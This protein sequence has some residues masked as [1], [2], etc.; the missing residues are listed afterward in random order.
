MQIQ[1]E[2]D[3]TVFVAN[4]GSSANEEIIFELFLQAGPLKKVTIARDREG[5]QRSYGFVYYKHAEAVPYAIALLNGTW[6]FGR[7][8]RL[9]YGTGSSHQD[10]GSGPQGT[11]DDRDDPSHDTPS[12]NVGLPESSVFHF[13]GRAD[14]SVS[15]QDKLHWSNMVRGYP[16]EQYPLSITPPQPHYYV[17]PSPLCPPIAPLLPW[18]MPGYPQ[19]ALARPP[20]PSQGQALLLPLPPSSTQPSKQTAHQSEGPKRQTAQQGE[21]ETAKLRKHRRSRESRLQR[22]RNRCKK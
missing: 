19:W 17:P 4:L 2:A 14:G 3:K 6:L 13:T 21:V 16:S 8:I 18:P 11:E 1:K 5:R 10:G 15:Y 22:H 12:M 7:Q 9:Q 20:C